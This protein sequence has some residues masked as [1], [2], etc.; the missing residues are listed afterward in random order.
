MFLLEPKSTAHMFYMDT[1]LTSI[2]V[3]KYYTT[4]VEQSV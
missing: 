1:F 3:P 2:S 4:S